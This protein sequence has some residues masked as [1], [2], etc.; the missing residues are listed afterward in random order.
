MSALGHSRRISGYPRHVRYSPHRDLTRTL[1][2][3]RKVPLGDQ[4]HRSKY[5]R[6]SITSSATAR[7]DDGNVRPSISPRSGGVDDQLELRCLHHWQ[8]RNPSTFLRIRP[9]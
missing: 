9:A 7:S 1:L 8:V 4:M 5:R 2:D 6:Y 3:V